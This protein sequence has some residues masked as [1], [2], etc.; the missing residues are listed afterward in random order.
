MLKPNGKIILNDFHPF[1][2]VMPINFF[3]S[4]VEDYFDTNIHS[5]DVAYKDFLD[6]EKTKNSQAVLSDYTILVKFLIQ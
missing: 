4:S 3:K 6:K 1:R 5:G 2:K